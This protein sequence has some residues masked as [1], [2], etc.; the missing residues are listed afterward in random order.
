[1]CCLCQV[2]MEYTNMG[3][4]TGCRTEWCQPYD[5]KWACKLCNCF[6]HHQCMTPL[7]V[8][9]PSNTGSEGVCRSCA[10]SPPPEAGLEEDG[11]RRCSICLLV[12]KTVAP[13]TVQ[14]TSCPGYSCQ[15]CS[16]SIALATPEC[17][18]CFLC[19]KT[20]QRLAPKQPASKSMAPNQASDGIAAEG[21]AY[22]AATRD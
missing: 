4:C 12:A 14:G 9:D 7:A 8:S 1:M 3:Y 16:S 6:C 17:R 15:A 2:P 18:V 13:C 19:A 22:H 20:D 10:C 11:S 21:Y 5:P